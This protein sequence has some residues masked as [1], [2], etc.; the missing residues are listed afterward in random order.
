MGC[1]SI[2]NVKFDQES[3]RAI[4]DIKQKKE[5]AQ[6]LNVAMPLGAMANIFLGNR[7]PEVGVSLAMTDF[8][9][10]AKAM[11]SMPAIQR[12]VIRDIA[13]MQAIFHMGKESLFWRGIANGCEIH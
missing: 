13:T 6:A 2:D 11:K 5:F 1:I 7:V 10:L 9:V 3:I 4:E 8:E 12:K